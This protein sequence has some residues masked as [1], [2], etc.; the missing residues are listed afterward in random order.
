MGPN[1]GNA[2]TMKPDRR[3]SWYLLT[4]IVLGVAVGLVYSWLISP[5]KYV[6][7]PPFALRADYKDDY[8]LM[9]AL[10]YMYSHDLLRAEDRLAQLKDANPA[11]EL[12]LQAQRA[13]S[14]GYPDYEVNALT[15]LAMDL[16]SGLTPQST[17]VPST[18]QAPSLPLNAQF[19]PPYV[20]SQPTSTLAITS[21]SHLSTPPA[22]TSSFLD[23]STSPSSPNLAEPFVLQET[24]MLC[25]QDQPLSLIQVDL[26]DAAGQPVPSVEVLVTWEGG[27][28]HFFT[29][30]HPDI[31]LGY[32]DFA[33]SPGVAYSIQPANGQVVNDLATAEC[34]A[35]DGTRFW[36][37]W[38]LVFVQQ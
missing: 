30:L 27:Q 34:T 10:A 8:R 29:G 33:M 37:S 32:G 26:K 1:A 12:T 14:E 11:Q 15:T 21:T 18:Q 3:G 36:G 24:R 5:V 16:A 38:Y 19:T 31:G 28:D 35:E 7:A 4:G 25:N 20:T 22:A 23:V 13:V 2:H 6:D 9:V 17:Q